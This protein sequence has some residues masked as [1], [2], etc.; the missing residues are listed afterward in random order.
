MYNYP[1]YMEFFRFYLR[2]NRK[3]FARALNEQQEIAMY[4]DAEL[5]LYLEKKFNKLSYRRR[6]EILKFLLL[7]CPDIVPSYFNIWLLDKPVRLE[8]P[9]EDEHYLL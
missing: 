3:E 1:T 9:N 2:M 8:N 6:R 7:K 5:I 4:W